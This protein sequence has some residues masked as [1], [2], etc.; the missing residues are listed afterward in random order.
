M[1][2]KKCYNETCKWN[3]LEKK[4]EMPCFME[5]RKCDF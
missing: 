5:V 3:D 4:G 2:N 1:E